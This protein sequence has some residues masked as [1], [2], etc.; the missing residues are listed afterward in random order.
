[1]PIF[2]YTC[3][4]C[5]KDFEALVQPGSPVACAGCGSTQLK[6][7]FSVFATKTGG[8]AEAA[9]PGCACG[10][11]GGFEQGACGSG[12]CGGQHS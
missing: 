2:E 11:A 9:M 12:L 4:K 1:M 10:C 6:K 5:G 7:K 3:K 8:A